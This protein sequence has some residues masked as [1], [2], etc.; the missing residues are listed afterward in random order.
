MSSRIYLKSTNEAPRTNLQHASSELRSRTIGPN[1]WWLIELLYW[2]K[3][4]FLLKILGIVTT[5]G[6]I[7]NLG[8]LGEYSV[9]S[10]LCEVS[11]SH[12]S[13][14]SLLDIFDR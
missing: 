4:S 14:Y 2:F 5:R 8:C 1:D 13:D 3:A 11:L 6:E 9:K 7:D 12:K 10:S